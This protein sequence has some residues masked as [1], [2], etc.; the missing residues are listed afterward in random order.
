ME[1]EVPEQFWHK[2]TFK[3]KWNYARFNQN[4]SDGYAAGRWEKKSCSLHYAV[5]K[6][7]H[8]DYVPVKGTSIDHVD[9]NKKLDNREEN[10]R[11]ADDSS[12]QRNKKKVGEGTYVGVKRTKSGKWVGCVMH[13]G[14]YY[15]TPSV[16]SEREAAILLNALRIKVIGPGAFLNSIED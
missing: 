9:P 12:Q 6:L 3:K 4:S 5:W 10:L 2:L 16:P 15:T 8:P 7:L 13:K 14:K 11:L 1:T